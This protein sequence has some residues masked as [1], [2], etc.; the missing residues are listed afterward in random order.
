M[1]RFVPFALR[2]AAIAAA[3][4]GLWLLDARLGR[5][6]RAAGVAAG[7]ATGV[8][9][10]L[11]HEWGHWLGAQAAGGVVHAP[12]TITSPFL[13][14]FDTERSSREQFLT[15]SYGGYIASAVSAVAVARFVPRWAL[16]GKVALGFV[17]AGLF[18]TAVAEVPTT[19]RVLRGAPLPSGGVYAGD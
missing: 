19:I 7:L 5:S 10:F 9:A 3:T 4:A 14:H 12:G 15:M 16:S 17:A 2:D 18:V 1:H 11:T 6:S 8:V 13:F